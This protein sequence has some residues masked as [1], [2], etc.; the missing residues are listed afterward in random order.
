MTVVMTVA[1]ATARMLK[2]FRTW[3]KNRR[4][5]LFFWYT[6]DSQE[7]QEPERSLIELPET[8]R[9]QLVNA[10]ENLPSNAAD[11][12][13]IFSSLDEAFNL[14]REN[15]NHHN[16]SVVILSSPVT[17]VSCILSK[18]LEEIGQSKSKFRCDFYL[19]LLD[20]LQLK[21][22]NLSWSII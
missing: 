13:A 10:I 2:Q 11:K 12:E 6:K 22:S 21:V 16:N 4:H 3:L 20:Q 1:E 8:L 17:A 5:F 14:W 18:T 19:Q 7:T 15:P 9:K